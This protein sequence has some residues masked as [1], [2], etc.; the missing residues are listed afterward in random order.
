MTIS[1]QIT[2]MGCLRYNLTV[3][4]FQDFSVSQILREINFIE[5]FAIFAILEAMSFAT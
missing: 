3:W 5:S 2:P 4:T 1:Q